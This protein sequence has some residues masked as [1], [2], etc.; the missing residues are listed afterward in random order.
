[1]SVAR[2]QP[3]KQ[4]LDRIQPQKQAAL[5]PQEGLFDDNRIDPKQNVDSAWLAEVASGILS[6]S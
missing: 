2:T 4:K 1:M 6:R 5:E 3:A